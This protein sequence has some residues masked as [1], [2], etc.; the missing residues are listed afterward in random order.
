MRVIA[1]LDQ[2]W[3]GRHM[4]DMLPRL[5]SCTF[6]IRRSSPSVTG[7]SW[8]SSSASCPGQAGGGLRPLR[9]CRPGGAMRQRPRPGALRAVLRPRTDSRPKT[10]VLRHVSR[11]PGL[12]CVSRRARVRAG[13]AAGATTGRARTGWSSHG[14]LGATRPASRA[15]R[16]APAAPRMSR[17]RRAKAGISGHGRCL[18]CL[19]EPMPAA[20]RDSSCQQ[21]SGLGR[22]GAVIQTVGRPPAA[23]ARRRTRHRGGPRQRR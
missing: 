1:V 16:R 4:A 21:W 9:G 5:F 19:S 20:C 6:G 12:A 13:R 14:A 7:S 22:P 15:P 23:C 17:A 10:G 8:A 18:R 11:E 3:G 2:W